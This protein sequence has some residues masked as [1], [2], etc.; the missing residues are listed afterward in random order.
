MASI[1]RHTPHLTP[2]RTPRAAGILAAALAIALPG[3]APIA[4]D[5]GPRTGSLERLDHNLTLWA[6]NLAANPHDYLSATTLATLYHGR[7]RLTAD[8]GDYQQALV[9][10]QTA[11]RIAPTYGPARDL[12]AAI[13]FTLHDFSGAFAMRARSSISLRPA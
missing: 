11:V 9:A 12:E 1:T 3:D 8:L 13:R 10:A 4:V 7:G 5:P 2:R 6:A